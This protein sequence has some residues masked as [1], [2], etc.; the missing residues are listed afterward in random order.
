MLYIQS[1]V[2]NERIADLRRAA[3]RGR[4]VR[5][6][7]STAE[8]PTPVRWRRRVRRTR[9]PEAASVTTAAR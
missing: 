5:V 6:A 9:S 1:E 8:A 7:R 3:D 2:A 4:R